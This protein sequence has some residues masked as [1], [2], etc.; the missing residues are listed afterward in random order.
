[1]ELDARAARRLLTP[2]ALRWSA[3][4]GVLR[5]TSDIPT[6]DP[7][8]TVTVHKTF[9]TAGELSTALF[10]DGA[11]AGEDIGV[12]RQAAE[13]T[14]FELPAWRYRHSDLPNISTDSPLQRKKKSL[15]RL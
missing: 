4:Q 11:V 7:T 10:T 5:R 13:T 15:N 6:Q 12:I 2:H 14:S 8:Y 3:G 1:M 9:T